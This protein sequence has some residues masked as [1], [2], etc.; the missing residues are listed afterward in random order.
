M[1]RGSFIFSRVL[2]KTR[3]FNPF[4]DSVITKIASGK[5]SDA[6]ATSG[7]LNDP[8]VKQI[9]EGITKLVDEAPAEASVS[10]RMVPEAIRKRK[11][12]A[13]TPRLVSVGPL[14]SKNKHLQKQ[15]MQGIKKCYAN[16]LF[17]RVCIV[18]EKCNEI[19]L[20]SKV[21]A[22]IYKC[23]AAM[24]SS[25]DEAKKFYAKKV[26]LDEA[27]LVIDGCFVL[28]VLRR[29]RRLLNSESNSP[30]HQTEDISESKQDQQIKRSETE[31]EP[32]WHVLD[33]AFMRHSLQHDLLLF[34]NQ[35]PYFVLQSL[36]ELT[37][38]KL[39]ETSESKCLSLQD[40]V[41]SYWPDI[42]EIKTNND[43][44]IDNAD[45]FY[46]ESGG[47]TGDGPNSKQ[48]GKHIMELKPRNDQTIDI[49]NNFNEESGGKTGDGADSRREVRHILHLLHRHYSDIY[50][51]GK[52]PSQFKSNG[53]RLMPSASKL[54]C[55]GIKFVSCP[56]GHQFDIEFGNAKGPLSWCRRPQFQIPIR[57]T[58]RTEP[59]LRNLI[60][61]EQCCQ[62]VGPYFTSYAFLMDALIDTAVDVEVLVDAKV[63]QN[64]FETSEEAASLYNDLIKEVAPDM[65]RFYFGDICQKADTYSKCNW[66]K[67]RT[68]PAMLFLHLSRSYLLNPWTFIGF[69]LAFITV[70]INVTNFILGFVLT[71][72]G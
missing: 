2:S 25:I 1:A 60:A 44:D 53:N 21:K 10:I 67:A 42:M 9:A 12:C 6:M 57:C 65:N 3:D 51:K 39:K 55:A 13:Y 17:T 40:Y 71:K 5:D 26:E 31:N 35:L 8:V 46:M 28:E 64:S 22:L 58:E 30:L 54:Y 18:D 34:E 4:L 48:E 56:R 14:H 20:N 16:A 33:S 11:R 36:F 32:S 52:H 61:F 23:T 45:D 50:L 47:G 68:W 62:D 49:T 7:E 29:N 19:E 43:K 24:K 70:G 66:A 37:L 41:I 72:R 69:F 59:L 15:G 63:M 38:G 27:M